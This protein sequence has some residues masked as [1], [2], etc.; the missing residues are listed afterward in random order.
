MTSRL[1]GIRAE[2]YKRLELVELTFPTG[3]GTYSIMGENEAGKSST[4][5]AVEVA[6]AGRKSAAISDKKPVRSG[7]DTAKI[8][9]TFDDIIV[10]RVFR[11][12]KPTQIKV[13]DSNGRPLDGDEA[14]R[15]LYSHVALDPLAFSRLTDAEQVA[16]LLPMIGFDPAP[17]N[18]AKK[19]AAELRL[20][21]GRE[22]DTRKGHLASLPDPVPGLPAELVSV[23]ALSAEL[24]AAMG[25]KARHEQLE[26]ALSASNVN[27]ARADRAVTEQEATIARVEAQLVTEKAR[28]Q[29]LIVEHASAA[30]AVEKAEADIAAANDEGQPEVE[31]IREQIRTA[32]ATNA[33]ISRRAD[34]QRVEAEVTALV[35]EYDAF[36]AQ[37]ADLEKQKATAL[38]AASAKMPVPGLTVEGDDDKPFLALNGQ[39]FAQASTGVKIRTGS[40][41]AMALNPALR[42][43]IIRDASLLD[44][45]NR[46]VLDELAQANDF[47]ILMEIAD[48]SGDT[49]AV[50]VDGMVSEV[51]A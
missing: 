17:I 6:I 32:Q 39:P 20:L 28:L 27:M 19:E 1:I 30:G 33:A 5:D 50:L 7:K 34:R 46:E 47:L 29:D 26:T 25:Q 18:A 22:R 36:T 48:T 44:H 24:E 2:N 49:G 13:T 51:R 42:L 38:A 15:K 9:A 40:A 35:A 10:T 31:G 3:G 21:K 43:I 14:L 4:L 23:D 12:G 45:G 41:I 11:T 16:T 37:I 8:V